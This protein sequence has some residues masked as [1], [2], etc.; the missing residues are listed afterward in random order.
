MPNGQV[1]TKRLAISTTALVLIAIIGGLLVFW[2]RSTTVVLVIRHAERD[3]SASCA[4]ATV[5]GRQNRPLI[6][7]AGQSPRAQTLAHVG[8][9]DGIAA[10][11]ASEFCL[12]P[13]LAL[14]LRPLSDRTSTFRPGAIAPRPDAL[15]ECD[16]VASQSALNPKCRAQEC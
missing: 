7:V 13:L 8:G 11:Y 6:M 10:I 5:Y 15:K 1:W 4:P 9:E 12:T 3:D 2:L 16:H 14:R